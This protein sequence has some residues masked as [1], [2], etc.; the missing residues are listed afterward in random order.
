MGHIWSIENRYR[1]WLQIEILVCEALAE[2]GD[3]PEEAVE[4]I[5]QRAKFDVR[6]IEEI[7][8]LTRHDLV[9]F[10]ECVSE[11]VGDEAKYIHMGITSSDILDT[12]LAICLRDS[13]DLIIAGLEGLIGLLEEKALEHRHT[14]MI[15]RTHGVHAEPI[16][17]GMK[18]LM[19]FVEVRRNLERIKKARQAIA[20]GKISGAVGTYAHIPPSVEQY[21]CERLDLKAE[22]IS[23]QIVQRD[24]H[25]EFFATLAILASSMEK[26]AL[27]IRNLQRTEVLEVEE[28]FAKGQKGSSAMPHKRNPILSENI[29]G[30]ARLVRANAHASLENIALWHERD[31]SHSS[32]ERVIAPDSTILVD[33]MIHRLTAIL[34]GM[35]IYPERMALNLQKTRGLIYSEGLLLG[36]VKKGL[37]RWEA[38]EIVQ[39]NAMKTWKGDED[40]KEQ[41]LSDNDIAKQLSSKEID[42]CFDPQTSLC[43]VDEIYERVFGR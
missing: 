36:L 38:Y 39:R 10:L 37:S 13:A 1:I 22:L 35:S 17:F 24:R 29:C 15:G 8:A 30:L 26:F 40:F 43:H 19:W 23:T 28:P 2:I 6:R 4:I 12:S 33:Y 34:K 18:M 31:I 3:I 42:E 5:R 21:V 11:S 7:E 25:G 16:T 9:A 27:E 32:V 41:V 14:I 20:F